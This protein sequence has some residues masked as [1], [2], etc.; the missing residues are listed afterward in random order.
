MSEIIKAIRPEEVEKG[1]INNTAA[2]FVGPVL[3]A[4][5]PLYAVV[6]KALDCQ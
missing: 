5:F 4:S 3:L 2:C 6:I 1:F